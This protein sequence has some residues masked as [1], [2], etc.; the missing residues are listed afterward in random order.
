MKK[1]IILFTVLI[2]AALSLV[3]CGGKEAKEEDKVIKIGIVGNETEVWDHIKEELKKENINIE[4]VSFTDYNQPNTALAE[5]EIDLNSFQHYA[6][7][8]KFIEDHKLNLSVVGETVM[9]PL[10]IYSNKID[11]LSDIEIGDKVAIQN[12][13][14]NGGRAL[15]LLETAGLIELE[16]KDELPTL[17]DIKTNKFDLEIIEMD[18]ATIPNVLEDVKIA[19][20]NSGIAVDFGFIPTEDSIFLEPV[21]D[22]TKPYIN[23]IVSREEEKDNEKYKKI[24]EAYQTDEVEK[25]L[26][27]LNKGSQI[28]VW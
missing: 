21:N 23:V 7:L 17:K 12:D 26:D 28:T 20:I 25:I 5:G 6:F 9:A 2:I 3:S 16:T 24:V 18:A 27:R 14:T 13:V 22:K 4:V 11:D 10:G 19:T 1:K 8:N 15:I